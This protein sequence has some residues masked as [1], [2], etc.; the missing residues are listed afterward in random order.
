M[1]RSA[2][3][4]DEDGGSAT[5][6]VN[7][8]PTAAGRHAT[9]TGF[10]SRR[11][12]RAAFKRLSASMTSPT[13]RPANIVVG[14]RVRHG[15]RSCS[16]RSS[17]ATRSSRARPRTSSP[18]SKRAR[19]V[20]KLG[21]RCLRPLARR[22]PAAG[23]QAAGM[24]DRA[25]RKTASAGARRRKSA[26]SPPRASL[27]LPGKLWDCSNRSGETEIFLVEGDSAGGS[28]KSGARSEDSRRSCPCAAR[29]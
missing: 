24:G 22:Q 20:D 1:G 15:G 11:P 2:W 19:I 14:R 8:V 4:G 3:P 29:S 6:I 13:R 25:A 18:P 28:A 21:A 27:R 23:D 16:C 9:R 10:L 26:G 17:C 5:P 7:T 12:R